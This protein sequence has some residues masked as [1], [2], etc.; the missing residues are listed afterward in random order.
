MQVDVETIKID[1]SRPE[2]FR[3][4]EI[5]KRAK[6]FGSHIF[7]FINEFIDEIRHA[8]AAA[9]ADDI[10]GDLIDDADGEYGGVPGAGMSRLPHCQTRFLSN[11]R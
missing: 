4:G 10:R 1:I 3:G 9:P 6:T 2:I 8:G 7:D 5:P 11:I